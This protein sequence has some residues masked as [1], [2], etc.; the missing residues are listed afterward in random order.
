MFSQY[1]AYKY[2]TNVVKILV[3]YGCIPV[4]HDIVVFIV[5]PVK[6]GEKKVRFNFHDLSWP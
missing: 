1:D 2:L 4:A 3:Y 5:H 6:S